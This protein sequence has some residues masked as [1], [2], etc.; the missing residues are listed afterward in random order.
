MPAFTGT[1]WATP[2][3]CLCPFHCVDDSVDR[4]G[5]KRLRRLRSPLDVFLKFELQGR[6]ILFLFLGSILSPDYLRVAEQALVDQPNRCLME[7]VRKRT[8]HFLAV[9]DAEDFLVSDSFGIAP[10]G[11]R[12]FPS[13]TRLVRPG[14]RFTYPIALDLFE[15]V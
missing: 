2:L 12:L 15:P 5:F 4:V 14:H 7:T 6:L 13:L 10:H 11:N 3:T 9:P 1:R 8:F